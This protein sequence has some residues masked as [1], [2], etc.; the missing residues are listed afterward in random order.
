VSKKKKKKALLGKQSKDKLLWI[1][2]ST[3]EVAV[4]MA[5]YG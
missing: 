3:T 1:S 2:S 4:E 5:L